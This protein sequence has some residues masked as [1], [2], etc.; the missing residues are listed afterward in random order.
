[1]IKD[2][3]KTIAGM[4]EAEFVEQRSRF[5]SF[6][7]F[8]DSEAAALELVEHYRKEYNDSRHV[9]WAYMLGESYDNYRANDDG[10]PSGTAGRPILG[11][12]NSHEL[13]NII[14]LVVRYFG[15][16]KLGT[17]GLVSAYQEGAAKAIE[18]AKI[19]TKIIGKPLIFR[20]GYDATNEV[21]QALHGL[22]FNKVR[23]E[24]TDIC[25]V[26]LSVRARDY[27]ALYGRLEALPSVEI[28]SE[29][30]LLNG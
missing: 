27:E 8:V 26:E 28:L 7:H 23:E 24:F 13:T 12:I 17:G 20:Y 15:G 18:N 6:A 16:I 1:M 14:V 19:V 21:N 29:K 3:Y 22:E 25:L 2:T 10:E 9:C 5:I 30:E 11:Q 4:A